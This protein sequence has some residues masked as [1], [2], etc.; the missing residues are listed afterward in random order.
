MSPTSQLNNQR[1]EVTFFIPFILNTFIGFIL[2]TT[3]IVF[4]SKS[5]I[6]GVYRD[7]YL[8][9]CILWVA[10][11]PRILKS[12]P[13]RDQWAKLL[14]RLL[15]F[16]AFAHVFPLRAIRSHSELRLSSIW[17]DVWIVGQTVIN[18]SVIMLILNKS[19][20]LPWKSP[21]TKNGLEWSFLLTR[22]RRE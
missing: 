1:P 18:L 6:T 21:T 3:T 14:S 10:S 5:Y 15:V 20:S 19:S 4:N 17:W 8:L 11:M 2:V 22:R 9:L 12:I 13:E 16:Y 7:G